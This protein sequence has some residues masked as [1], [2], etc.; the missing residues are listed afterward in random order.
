MKEAAGVILWLLLMS[1]ACGV[2]ADDGSSPVASLPKGVAIK[3]YKVN[4]RTGAEL[5]RSLQERGP[6]DWQGIKRHALTIWRL[7]WNWR[8]RSDGKMAF[9]DTILTPSVEVS[10]PMWIPDVDAPLPLREEWERYFEAL[11]SHE[12]GH[13][14]NFLSNYHRVRDEIR[15]TFSRKPELTSLE[16]NKLAENVLVELQEFDR[17]YDSRT[18]N[19]ERD[20]VVFAPPTESESGVGRRRLD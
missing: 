1:F 19:G 17:D 8:R 18:K 15:E 2:I 12:R 10:L 11:V 6:S 3:W 16:A 5:K 4:G 20:G 9:D 13:I 14:E 7:R